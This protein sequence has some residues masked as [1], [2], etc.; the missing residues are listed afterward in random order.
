MILTIGPL[1]LAI[2]GLTE[3]EIPA[4][5]RLFIDRS[6]LPG[7]ADIH[8]T[9]HFVDRLSMPS[10]DWQV[11]FQ[12]NDIVVFKQED[13]EARLLAVGNMQAAYALYQ[14]R[15]TEEVDIYFF[16]ALKQELTID[17]MFAS[18]LCLERPLSQRGCYILHCAYLDYRGQA[19]LFSGA[20]GIGKSTHA[21]LWC[22][23]IPDTRVL[24]GDRALFCPSP[25]GGYEVQGWPVCGS[26][27]ICHNER[28]PL[29]TI[30]F[31][32]QAP[33]NS[34]R[35][36]TAMQHFKALTSQVTINWWNPPFTRRALD[37][38][39]TLTGAISINT[40]ACNMNPEAAFTLRQHLENE[41]VIGGL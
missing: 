18:C 33:E 5:S 34:I 41:G 7:Q 4:N 31:M 28:R 3:E 32:E 22:R 38:L 30:V 17:T 15:N 1:T 23:T 25:D 14:E 29:R 35:P 36:K 8:Y 26:S 2:S 10:N 20:S 21:D 13:R 27:G 37:E 40:Y 6:D 24:N 19:I 9:F 11:A 39:L 12:R 16:K